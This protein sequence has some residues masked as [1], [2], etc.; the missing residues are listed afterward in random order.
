MS[1]LHWTEKGSTGRLYHAEYEPFS[2]WL[3]LGRQQPPEEMWLQVN[4]GTSKPIFHLKIQTPVEDPFIIA[5][6]L[7]FEKYVSPM[8]MLSMDLPTKEN[9]RRRKYVDVK[10]RS[11]PARYLKGLPKDLQEQRIKELGK[12]RD[13][14][15]RGDYS[16]LPTD[17]AARK[18]GLVKKSAYSEVAEDRGIEWRGDA[19]DMAQRVFRY[20]KSRGSDDQIDAFADALTSSYNKGLAAWKS[21]GHRPGA[22][23]KNWAVARVASLVVGGKTAWTADRKE[24]SVLPA[25]IRKKIIAQF[26]D[27][28][29]ALRDQGRHEDVE[30]IRKAVS[31]GKTKKNPH[32]FDGAVTVVKDKKG[33]ILLLRRSPTDPWKP[34]F[35]NL[36]GGRIEPKEKPVQSAA[37]ELAEEAGLT[38]SKLFDLGKVDSGEGWIVH[39]FVAQ[40]SDWEGRVRLDSENDAYVWVTKED[41]KKLP[42][43]PT[44][45]E[46]LDQV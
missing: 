46:I 45:A 37:R 41:A 15:K 40:P 2:L 26:D 5:E 29:D 25:A 34:G 6:N 19:Y 43:I 32:V 36:P 4:R 22:T 18:L 7:F 21:G 14:Y 35:W 20:Y 11:I 30:A 24:F 39:V 33:R 42:L 23:A 38:V 1:S 27:V 13:A 10:G 31:K 16:E 28:A 3:T 44:L 12:S 17:R 8:E 9:P